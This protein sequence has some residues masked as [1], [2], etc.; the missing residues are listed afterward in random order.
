MSM[1]PSRVLSDGVSIP[2]IGFGTYPLAGSQAETAVRG[3]LEAGYRLIDT[4]ASYGNENSVGRAVAAS[5]L[6]REEVFLTTKLR[7]RD[8][9]YD[10]TLAAFADSAKRL[11][12]DYVDLYL[13]HWPLPRLDAYVDSWRA[14]IKLREQGLVRS[15]GVSNFT[16]RQIDRLYDETGVLPSVNQIEMHPYFPQPQQRAVHAARNITTQSWSPLGRGSDLLAEPA[17][18]ETARRHGVSPAQVVLRWHLQLDALP[19]PKSASPARQR[20]NV[21]LFGFTLTEAEV[22]SLSALMRSRTGGDPEKHEEF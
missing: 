18:V 22:A 6:P 5:G 16:A 8:H 19:I 4:A 20:A 21:D 1:V 15:I 12:V 7:G 13:I 3:A 14:M 2:V 17:V 9:G 10:Q 11:G